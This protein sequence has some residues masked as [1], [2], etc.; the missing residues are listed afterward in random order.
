MC[1][2]LDIQHA[3]VH[4]L[5][6]TVTLMKGYKCNIVAGDILFIFYPSGGATLKTYTNGSR[7]DSSFKK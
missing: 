1:F 4:Y 6:Y 3:V 7:K 5:N 2:K